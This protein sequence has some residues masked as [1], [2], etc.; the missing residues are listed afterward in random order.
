[1]VLTN[2][3]IISI[4]KD[5]SFTKL[6]MIL[7]TTWKREERERVEWKERGIP[8]FSFP[9]IH[10]R[11]ERIFTLRV[12]LFTCPMHLPL[13]LRV[14]LPSRH[15]VIVNAI[16]LH[17]GGGF[18]RH[19]NKAQPKSTRISFNLCRS[20]S[21]ASFVF[22]VKSEPPSLSFVPAP[23]ILFTLFAYNCVGFPSKI[24]GLRA[25]CVDIAD[26]LHICHNAKSYYWLPW[27]LVL[28]QLDTWLLYY[29][30]SWIRGL[31][32]DLHSLG[33]LGRISQIATSSVEKMPSR[34]CCCVWF[35]S[36]SSDMADKWEEPA[37]AT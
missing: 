23:R 9:R 6:C 31:G 27:V 36:F 19:K 10:H 18:E 1:M 16:H 3:S 12:S 11:I 21:Q 22:D 13:P 37:G 5:K 4:S 25:L 15:S 26:G 14:A 35:S 20:L 29:L 2:Y 32:P 33:S 8:T 17:L 24:V 30:D 28:A 7:Y 34:G